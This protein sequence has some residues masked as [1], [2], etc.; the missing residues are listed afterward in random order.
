MGRR[1]REQDVADRDGERKW[2]RQ[3]WGK[4]GERDGRLEGE[5]WG[6]YLEER[7]RNEKHQ[8]E[9]YRRERCKKTEGERLKARAGASWKRPRK[10]APRERYGEERDGG[11]SSGRE[12]ASGAGWWEEAR[13]PEYLQ[14]ERVTEAD[15]VVG[16][17][18]GQQGH[19]NW[20]SLAQE[21]EILGE[22]A[23]SHL[24][25]MGE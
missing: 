11:A 5:I 20:P 7:E 13:G 18:R 12:G 16:R 9:R 15:L 23:L 2:G 19:G 6:R 8:K 17:G 21:K 22:S 1:R 3:R 25:V 24:Q 4:T 14:E 10:D